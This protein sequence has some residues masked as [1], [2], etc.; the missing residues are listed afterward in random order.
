MQSH[1]LL[2]RA[3][4]TLFGERVALSIPHFDVTEQYNLRADSVAEYRIDYGEENERRDKSHSSTFSVFRD[5]RI[6]HSLLLEVQYRKGPSSRRCVKA[7]M[8]AGVKAT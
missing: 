2:P 6:V 8:A 4:D 5:R 1:A 3:R 7:T